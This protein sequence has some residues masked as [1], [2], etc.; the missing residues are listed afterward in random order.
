MKFCRRSEAGI[1]YKRI[2]LKAGHRFLH[3]GTMTEMKEKRLIVFLKVSWWFFS[4]AQGT[5][6]RLL[7]LHPL[8]SDLMAAKSKLIPACNQYFCVLPMVQFFVNHTCVQP[9]HPF[10]SGSVFFDKRL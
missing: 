5:D 4:H 9:G 6:C 2:I 1:P 10:I 3:Q 7:L 8:C